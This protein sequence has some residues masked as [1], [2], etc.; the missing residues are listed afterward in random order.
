MENRQPEKL[1]NRNSL[2]LIF[3]NVLSKFGD[4]LF[5]IAV[6]FYV[7]DVTNSE[8]LMGVFTSIT[9]FVTMFVSPFSGAI[10]D[11]L[12][13]KLIICGM[14]ILRGILMVVVGFLCVKSLLPLELLFALTILIAL[15]TVLFQ[16]AAS[17]I[18]IDVVPKT[19]YVRASSI[20]SSFNG[21]VDLISKGFSGILLVVFGVGPLLI[22]NGIFFLVSAVCLYFIDVPK[23]LKEGSKINL[24]IIINDIKEGF[25]ALIKTKGLNAFF[26]LAILIN[27]CSAG[28]LNLLL[29][30]ANEKGFSLQQYG[31]LMSML[32]LGSLIGALPTSLLKIKAEHRP[33]I[34]II[35]FLLGQLFT[36]VGLASLNFLIVIIGLFIGG[37]TNT[38]GN[39]VLNSTIFIMIPIE[40]RATILGFISSSG[41]GGF[42]LSTLVYGILAESISI[43]LLAIIGT[44]LGTLF[45][46]P[47]FF[48]KHL[49]KAVIDSGKSVI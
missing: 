30:V 33:W 10:V 12:N 23:T 4:V 46:L 40:K 7:Y 5:S 31:L 17:T 6:G 11:R 42:A 24:L 27:L 29:L 2:F 37:F 35:G 48:N 14:D 19:E 15:S 45:I 36:I 43:S 32:S 49:I 26:L 1:F 38:V 25:L 20:N 9:M 34:M 28:Y 13:R 22:F 16:P 39:L 18:L 8:A 41:M 21:V 44:A 3:G 47:L